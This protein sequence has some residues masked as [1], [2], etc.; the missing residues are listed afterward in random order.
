MYSF[1]NLPIP[2]FSSSG[3]FPISS[4]WFLSDFPV[5]TKASS[6]SVPEPQ[7]PLAW[8]TETFPKQYAE[9]GRTAGLGST[10]LS[11]GIPECLI[12]RCL[13]NSYVT[14]DYYHQ[15]HTETTYIK[16]WWYIAGRK[17]M[18]VIMAMMVEVAWCF[19]YSLTFADHQFMYDNL[20]FHFPTWSMFP[21]LETAAAG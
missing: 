21:Q 1:L 8:A 18:A 20:F 3:H 7:F 6:F 19:D 5:I 14:W 11:S 2:V 10:P 4:Q 15:P 16:S 13:M 17:S 9:M 12:S